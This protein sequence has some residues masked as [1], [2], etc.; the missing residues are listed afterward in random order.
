MVMTGAEVYAAILRVILWGEGQL[1]LLQ[2]EMAI[3]NMLFLLSM[4]GAFDMYYSTIHKNWCEDDLNSF[5]SMIRI[6][7][8]IEMSGIRGR[9]S[10]A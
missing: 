10:C 8:S 4:S 6:D 7:F 2:Q 1:D 9:F 3:K 5:V